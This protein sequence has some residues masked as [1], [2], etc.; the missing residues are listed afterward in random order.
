MLHLQ[1]RTAVKRCEECDKSFESN[2]AGAR[3][4]KSR[5]HTQKVLAL[6][7]AL[8]MDKYEEI[9]GGNDECFDENH[10]WESGDDD[11]LASDDSQYLSE[12]QLDST[13][14]KSATR[15]VTLSFRFRVKHFFCCTAMHTVL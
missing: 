10:Q 9:W 11:G 14:T 8:L 15:L 5:S 4:F 3:H 13:W 6:R 2:E 1:Q 12:V 7:N